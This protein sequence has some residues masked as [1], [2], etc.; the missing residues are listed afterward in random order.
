MDICTSC[1]KPFKITISVPPK[2]WEQIKPKNSSDAIC[3]KCIVQSLEQLND[4]EH[5]S[6]SLIKEW[7]IECPVA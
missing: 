1:R 5:T 4:I 7:R 2:L 6:F 3:G